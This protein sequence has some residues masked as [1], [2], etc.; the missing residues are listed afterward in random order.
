MREAGIKAAEEVR[1][2]TLSQPNSSAE[3]RVNVDTMMKN[4]AR[5][6]GGRRPLLAAFRQFQIQ[7]DQ[8]RAR[9]G[10]QGIVARHKALAGAGRPNLAG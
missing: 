2:E 6:R 5:S 8:D 9:I 3:V 7:Y 4:P 1:E 10:V